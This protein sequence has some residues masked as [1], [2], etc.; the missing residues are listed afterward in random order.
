MPD[1][2]SCIIYIDTFLS[3][4]NELLMFR[5]L[6]K[7]NKRWA[8]LRLGCASASGAKHRCSRCQFALH[9]VL[10]GRTVCNLFPSSL[11]TACL[12]LDVHLF[13]FS[14][15]YLLSDSGSCRL[16]NIRA[17]GVNSMNLKNAG[18][19]G[20][21]FL[22]LLSPGCGGGGSGS[23]GDGGS[24]VGAASPAK[25]ITDFSFRAI[26]NGASS[27]SRDVTG[28]IDETAHQITLFMPDDISATGLITTF[29]TTGASVAVNGV[30]Q[31]SSITHND[32]TNPVIYRVTA[33]DGSTADYAVT[34]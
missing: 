28:T 3:M 10:C 9:A 8:Y 27:L 20:I 5:N 18:A 25:A 24:D 21:I 31:V 2:A 34:R 19:I 14:P 4:I 15:F 29:L 7:I 30:A 26:L 22:A 1:Y 6:L 23:S 33:S 11:D 13:I 12:I 17:W 32:F 16:S